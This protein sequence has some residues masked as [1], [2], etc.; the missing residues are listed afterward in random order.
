M[1]GTVSGAAEAWSG[2]GSAEW[3]LPDEVVLGV[4]ALD[5]RTFVAVS[6]ERLLAE[7]LA[8]QGKDGW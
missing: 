4:A 3:A 1:L 6:G 7:L 2:S 5:G 8:A